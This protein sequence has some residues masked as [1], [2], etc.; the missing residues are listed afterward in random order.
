M[1]RCI[2]P[3]LPPGT[4]GVGDGGIGEGA[5]EGD[6]DGVG[7]GDGD[8]DGEGAQ[9]VLFNAPRVLASLGGSLN[10]DAPNV[11]LASGIPLR[12]A[13]TPVTSK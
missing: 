3:Q 13:S 8:G 5:G 12:R 11:Q 2:M 1:S 9:S 4:G 10:S 7:E 6:G